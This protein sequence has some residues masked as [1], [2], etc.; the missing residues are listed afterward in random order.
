MIFET[1]RLYLKP[2]TA[3]ELRLWTE[4]LPALELKLDISYRAEPVMGHFLD[5]VKGQLAYVEQDASNFLYYTFWF[6]IRKADRVV[7]G[8]ADFKGGPDQNGEV[9][10]GYGLGRE[11]EHNGYMTEAV[12]AM[13]RWALKQASVSRVIAETEAENLPSQR[14]LERC[15][16]RRFKQEGTIW[17]KL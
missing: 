17:W 2:L 11:Y 4:N 16:F 10:L 6:L 8:S 14:I 3:H 1:D 7:V 5:I 12:Q 13:C 15:G 9:E